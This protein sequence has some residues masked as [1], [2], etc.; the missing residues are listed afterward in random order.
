MW[1]VREGFFGDSQRSVCDGS[2]L[3]KWSWRSSVTLSGCEVCVGR[4]KESK[5]GAFSLGEVRQVSLVSLSQGETRPSWSV[6]DE[7]IVTGRGRQ[8]VRR[9]VCERGP[10]FGPIRQGRSSKAWRVDVLSNSD[11]PA[12]AVVSRVAACISISVRGPRWE[13]GCPDSGQ[14]HLCLPG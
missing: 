5:S 14:Q 13:V 8:L 1:S 9:R 6:V 3:S 10:G 12:E 7:S 4:G 2:R 11:V